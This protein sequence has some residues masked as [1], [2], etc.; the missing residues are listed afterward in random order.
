MK[1]N[2]GK[3]WVITVGLFA[4]LLTFGMALSSAQSVNTNG[5]G[6]LEGT[7]NVRVTIR[8]CQTGN[9]IRSFDSLGIF[10]AGGT[11]IDSTSGTPQAL[12]TPGQGIWEHVTGDTYRFKFKS[13]SF[14]P[15]GNFTG[16]TI[17]RHQANLN[18]NADAY[19]SAGTAEVY[20]PNGALI[21]V[22]CSTSVATRFIFD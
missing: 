1:R 13:F 14:D 20:A 12:K 3:T 6:R 7:W 17:I 19:A 18:H 5:A 22:G 9:E 2:L 21:F 8:N 16:W 15:A 11:T 4:V 10:M